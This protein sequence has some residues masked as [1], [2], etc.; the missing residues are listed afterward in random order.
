[1]AT[2]LPISVPEEV[3]DEFERRLESA[4]RFLVR[5]ERARKAFQEGKGIRLKEIKW[6]DDEKQD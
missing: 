4:P 2:A 6:D 1:M 5:V 3:D